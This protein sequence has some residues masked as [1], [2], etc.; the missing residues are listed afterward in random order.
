[1]VRLYETHLSRPFFSPL[2]QHACTHRD[3]VPKRHTQERANIWDPCQTFLLGA[4]KHNDWNKATTRHPL[5]PIKSIHTWVYHTPISGSRETPIPA[6]IPVDFRFFPHNIDIQYNQSH[7]KNYFISIIFH[8]HWQNTTSSVSILS[9]HGTSTR[10]HQVFHSTLLWHRI[11]QITSVL[12][13]VLLVAVQTRY[14]SP[15]LLL[16]DVYLETKKED[17]MKELSM[18]E[19]KHIYYYFF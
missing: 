7:K 16:H 10:L 14:S 1:M 19:L 5:D 9:Q 4:S 18:K 2:P 15:V 8:N 13:M 17:Q 3:I 6:G 11:L 12:Q